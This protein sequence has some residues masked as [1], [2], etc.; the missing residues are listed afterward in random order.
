MFL[1]QIDAP[2][3]LSLSHTHTPV[4]KS[5]QAIYRERKVWILG[6]VK[7]FCSRRR[8]II[9]ATGESHTSSGPPPLFSLSHSLTGL[10]GIYYTVK[11]GQKERKIGQAKRGRGTIFARS[12]GKINYMWGFGCIY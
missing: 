11:A 12:T 10:E 5:G 4:H 7:V 6:K 3:S 9:M 2:L 1:S 8:I